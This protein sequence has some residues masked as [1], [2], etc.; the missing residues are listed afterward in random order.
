MVLLLLLATDSTLAASPAPGRVAP[1]AAPRAATLAAAIAPAV[2]PPP[3]G[4]TLTQS[5]TNMV[6]PGGENWTF[7]GFN[8]KLE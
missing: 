7:T 6:T 5:G 1:K 2:Y 8:L 3:G 4:V